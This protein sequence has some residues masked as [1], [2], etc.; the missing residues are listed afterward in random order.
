[1][2]FLDVTTLDNKSVRGSNGINAIG[3]QITGVGVYASEYESSNF[4]EDT[5]TDSGF[6]MLSYGSTLDLSNAD[7]SVCKGKLAGAIHAI[8]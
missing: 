6:I 7:I 3:S 5:E 8:G 1:M 4:I 2:T